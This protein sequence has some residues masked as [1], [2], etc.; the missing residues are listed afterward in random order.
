MRGRPRARCVL[1]RC[2]SHVCVAH[3]LHPLDRAWASAYA[4]AGH[5][6]R[7]LRGAA[8]SARARCR[9]SGTARTRRR[10][11]T[12]TPRHPTG[13]MSTASPDTCADVLGVAT[14][15]A[16]SAAEPYFEIASRSSCS[17]YS[18][19]RRPLVDDELDPVVR[20]V[21]S[22]LG[23]GHRAARVEVGDRRDLVVE[24]RRAVGDGAV[25]L[26]DASHGARCDGPRP[27]TQP[28]GTEDAVEDEAAGNCSPRAAAIAATTT[29]RPA[30]RRR[31]IRVRRV[32]LRAGSL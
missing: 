3:G 10:A 20:G 29:S 25:S 31:R 7:R 26:A 4:W 21:A 15:R 19:E 9:R 11:R 17:W 8:R 13:P 6:D 32:V 22:P 28:S 27:V 16:A 5:R 18:G 14:Q 24:D 1:V 30:T 23:A 2:A 12:A